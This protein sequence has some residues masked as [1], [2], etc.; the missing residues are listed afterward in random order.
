MLSCHFPSFPPPKAPSTHA[1]APP[2]TG[3]GAGWVALRASKVGKKKKTEDEN[4]F[5]NVYRVGFKVQSHVHFGVG[6][7][8]VLAVNVHFGL[9]Q[10]YIYCHV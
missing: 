10:K 4:N 6:I 3:D 8:R 2:K 7:A 1:L 5:F 9:H